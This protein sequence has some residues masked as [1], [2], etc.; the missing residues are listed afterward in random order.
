MPDELELVTSLAMCLLAALVLGY[1][2]QRLGLSP[3]VGYL[4]AG[5]VIGPRTPGFVADQETAAHFAEIG[6]V[7]LMF[8]VGLHFDLKDL[9]A[10]WRIAVPG[11]MLQILVATVLGAA[12]VAAGGLALSAGLVVGLAISVASTVVL[13]RVLS[14]NH[15]LGTVPGHIA[16]GWLVVED[17]FTVFVL[18][19]LPALS[20]TAGGAQA[21]LAAVAAAF[22]LAGL[23]VALLAAIVLGVGRYL[24]PRFLTAIARTR[25]KELFTLAVLATAL[26]IASGA[27]LAFGVSMALGAFL[28]GM[29]VGQSEVSHQAAADAL[30]MRDAFA[31]LF[32]VSAGMLFDPAAIAA[33]PALFAAL[34]AIILIAKPLT[35]AA[36]VLFRGY[37]VTGA[38]TVALGLAQIGEF[39]FIVANLAHEHAIIDAP[40]QSLVVACGIASVLAN[41]L[42]FRGIVPLERWLRARPRLWNLLTRRSQSAASELRSVPAVAATSPATQ[43]G[44]ASGEEAATET[45]SPTLAVIVGYGPVGQTASRILKSFGVLPVIVDLNV[46][47][48][49]GL[50]A[51]GE[52]AVYGDSTRREILQAAGIKAAKYLLITV[53]EIETRT[54]TTIVAK[55]L[56]PELVVFVR[57]RYLEERAWLEE[58]G[59]TE[60]CFEEAEAAIGLAGLLLKEV[61]APEERIKSELQ[62]IRARMALRRG[63]M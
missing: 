9:L 14:E 24:I 36:I 21:S 61:N 33:R 20:G 56:N 43:Q 55:D 58:V 1:A 7:L 54:V 49:K 35:A 11:A 50:L 62:A 39:S 32:F 29:V 4:L 60:A 47:T 57:A 17:L 38:L 18:V 53:P 3:I 37:S 51:A 41:P 44:N 2:T 63:A 5:I 23:K 34:L 42:M 13:V 6:V 45:D 40:T 46:D 16:I 25:T 15:A 12:A 27:A 30:P 26:A 10:V 31:V 22:A 59:A 8:G 52:S 28:A 19:A 48:V